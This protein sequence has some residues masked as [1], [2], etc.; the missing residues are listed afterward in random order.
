MFIVW[1]KKLVRRKLGYVADFCPLCRSQQ[2]FQL[3]R[4][5]SASHVY[6]LSAGEGEL[7]GFERKCLKCRT[8]FNADPSAY[9]TVCKKPASLGE[10][11]L[12]TF[13][14]LEQVL[15]QRLELEQKIQKNPSAL[16]A[17]ERHVLI[18]DPFL[19]LS[20]TVENRFAS[21]H[22]DKETAIAIV[23]AIALLM[24]GPALAQKIF[25][26]DVEVSVMIFIGVGLC[27]VGWQV[28]MSG[29]RFMRRKIVP[30][31]ADCLRPLQPTDRELVA[32][33]AE[34]KQ[35]KHKI[36]RKLKVADLRARMRE[37]QRGR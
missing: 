25:P 34:L 9:A 3:F 4:V 6:F 10:L 23:G 15:K 11:K 8:L 31:L 17:D 22:I 18:R 37:T 13:P 7:V 29:R 28:A 36:G 12:K 27:L 14:L 5:G 2:S 1:G 33:I 26:G 32:V 30:I 20:P 35:L 21:T 19:L 24:A 16:S